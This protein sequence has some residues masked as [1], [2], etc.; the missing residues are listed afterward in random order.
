MSIQLYT[1]KILE[2]SLFFSR[3]KYTLTCFSLPPHMMN[4]SNRK[5]SLPVNQ[6][7]IHQRWIDEKLM[8]GGGGT[9]CWSVSNGQIS[10]GQEQQ[11]FDSLSLQPSVDDC[12]TLCLSPL[13]PPRPHFSLISP[14]TSAR[15]GGWMP[16]SLG[17]IYSQDVPT[18]RPGT[19]LYDV[20]QSFLKYSYW[21]FRLLVGLNHQRW[22][23]TTISG[24]YCWLI[25]HARDC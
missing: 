15:Y 19:S 25:C 18:G 13:S 12:W 4:E 8:G 20:L 5:W 24:I 22:C 14:L 10:L 21:I 16:K 6:G 9:F 11:R 2:L 7:E 1:Y 23:M 17:N 3:F